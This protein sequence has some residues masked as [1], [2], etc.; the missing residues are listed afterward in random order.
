MAAALGA[1]GDGTGP[2]GVARSGRR[3]AKFDAALVCSPPSTHA[4]IAGDL[5]EVGRPVLCEKP[6][7][8]S[9][10]QASSMAE[11]AVAAGVPPRRWPQ[12]PRRRRRGQGP[13]VLIEDV[14][15][16]G[17]LVLVETSA[18]TGKVDMDQPMEQPAFSRCPARGVIGCGQRHRT[19]STSSGSL[20]GPVTAVAFAVERPRL[21][22]LDVEDTAWLF[23]R[24]WRGTSGAT[25]TSTLEPRQ[26][27]LDYTVETTAPRALRAFGWRRSVLPASSAW[28]GRGDRR[29]L[30][31]GRRHPRRT[32]RLPQPGRRGRGPHHHT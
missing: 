7:A 16:S 3:F 22:R 1:E 11:R 12:V 13:A 31:Q 20:I 21:Q 9:I 32:H 29:R 2:H 26:R 19:P 5:L 17:P 8:L 30:R 25:P 6:L 18:F 4:A 24:T 10:D 28:R 14:A 23:A 27:L 15:S